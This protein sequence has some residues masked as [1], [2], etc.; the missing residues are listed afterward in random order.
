[1]AL[2][3]LPADKIQWLLNTSCGPWKSWS[4]YDHF[5]QVAEIRD[6]LH[7]NEVKGAY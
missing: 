3:D 1:M 2:L 4:P 5:A 6:A 7:L